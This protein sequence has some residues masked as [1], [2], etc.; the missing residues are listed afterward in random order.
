MYI[1]FLT[2]WTK[3]AQ[4]VRRVNS[5]AREWRQLLEDIQSNG[6]G[7]VWFVM[8]WHTQKH[9]LA[10]KLNKV[11]RK[12]RSIQEQVFCFSVSSICSHFM[13]SHFMRLFVV[14]VV[15]IFIVLFCRLKSVCVCVWLLWYLIQFTS[16]LWTT[17]WRQ[18]TKYYAITY[19]TVKLS[20]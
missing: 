10:K 16:H 19:E 6:I 4:R 15:V 1:W 5:L 18:S 7:C 13:S 8:E 12:K 9:K 20:L 11:A 14:V 2:K 3:N 17:M